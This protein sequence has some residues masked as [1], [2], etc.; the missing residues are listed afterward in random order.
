M[1]NPIPPNTDDLKKGS[2]LPNSSETESSSTFN[3][4]GLKAPPKRTRRLQTGEKLRSAD[5]VERIPVGKPNKLDVDEPKNLALAIH[6]MKLKYVVITSVDRDDLRDGGA[7]HFADCIREAKFLSPN[8]KVEILVPD[9]RGRMAPA[10]DILSET[11]PHVFN[12]NLETVSR[13]YREAR[14]GANYAWSLKLL[15]EFKARNP[16]IQTKSG[17]MVGLGEDKD[18]LLRTLDD[19]REHDVDMLTVGQYLQPSAN[20]LAVDRF[21]HPDEFA[22]YTEYANSIGFKQAACGPL[23]RSSYHAD[24]QE[25]GEDVTQMDSAR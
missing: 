13:L 23:V 6:E 25:R 19:L 12:H 17:L 3:D 8:L 18:E 16:S 4:L 24:R 15:K 10:L 22:Q 14:P 5:K 11:P 1:T 20:H 2:E 9:F 21:V 7:Q